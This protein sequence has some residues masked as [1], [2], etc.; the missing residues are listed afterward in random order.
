MDRLIKELKEEHVE[1]FGLL[2][3]FK[4]G[5]GVDGT[6]WKEKLFSARKLFQDHLK[7]E[8]EELYPRLIKKWAGD[9][10]MEN[11][12][13]KFIADMKVI[14]KETMA[15][16]DRYDTTS[17]GSDFMKDYAEMMVDLKSRMQEEEDKLFKE[18][19]K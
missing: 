8:D 15:F 7:K 10:S 19:E 11:I 13:K 17:S 6:G 16:L 1:L 14:S 18:L 4:K 5:R 2:E 12:V 9:K 3:A